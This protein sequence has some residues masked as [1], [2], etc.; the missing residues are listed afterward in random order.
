MHSYTK[1]IDINRFTLSSQEL[2]SVGRIDNFIV[3]ILLIFVFRLSVEGVDG[4]L[5]NRVSGLI[6]GTGKSL[7]LILITAFSWTSNAALFIYSFC[8]KYRKGIIV[9]AFLLLINFIGGDRTYP[10]LAVLGTLCL[11]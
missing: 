7:L 4:L 8:Y 10:A 1:N 9:S 6:P 5:F 3:L 2:K 11:D